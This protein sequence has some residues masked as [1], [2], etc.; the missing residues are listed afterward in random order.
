MSELTDP[1]Q[2]RGAERRV[3]VAYSVSTAAAVGLA[4]VYWLGGEPQLEG[5]LL[6][7]ALGGI[8]IGMVMWAK[9]F[10]PH[11]EVA[12][13]RGRIASSEEE[14]ASFTAALE[15][16]AAAVGRRRLLLGLLGG[17]LAALA[18]AMVFPI[19][20]L[21][22]RPG[23]GLFET[24]FRPGVR[25]VTVTGVP[26]RAEDLSVGTVLT[27]WPE[28]AHRPADAPAVLIRVEDDG[29]F[30]DG[31]LRQG[32]VGSV[33]AYSK[34]CTHLGCPVGLYQ[35]EEHQLLC[36]CHQSAFDVLDGARPVSGPATRPLPQLPLGTDSD[37]FLV[38][39]GDYEEPV[40]AGFWNRPG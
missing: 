23:K 7:V 19:R 1:A 16:G 22:P 37:G 39:T 34:L 38:A 17:A 26:L 5:A 40:G 8:G 6:G 30:G 4:V 10:L 32:T 20:S 13:D 24:A 15:E 18:A 9:A 11:D 27:V 29:L 33:V 3:A 25:L 12:E 35:A 36:P 28:G 31:V 14:L 2:R 21:G